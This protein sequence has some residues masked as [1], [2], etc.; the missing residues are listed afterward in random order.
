MKKL[1]NQL[2]EL[3]RSNTTVLF[4]SGRNNVVLDVHTD[5][6]CGKVTINKKYFNQINSVGYVEGALTNMPDQLPFDDHG[7][8]M[9]LGF[10]FK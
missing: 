4:I 6:Y 5:Q 8:K 3:T 1:A 7:M 9:F 10:S 2:V